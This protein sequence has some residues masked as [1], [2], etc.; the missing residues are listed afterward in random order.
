[1]TA[2]RRA[3]LAALRV[4]QTLSTF[5][6]GA[7]VLGQIARRS[8]E[9]TYRLDDLSITIPNVGGARVPLYEVY[10]EDQY[11]LD[12]FAQDLG[13]APHL[14]DV[15]AHVGTFA[16]DFARRFPNATAQLF[17]PTPSTGEYLARNVA[18]NGLAD[19]FTVNHAALA[20]VAGTFLMVDN[21]LASGHNG[22]LRLGTG[23]GREIEVP[24]QGANDVL[25]AVPQ[26][27]LV[28]MDVEGAEYD[29]VL[30]TPTETWSRVRR[31]VMEYH[32]LE[33]HR[34]EQIVDHLGAAGLAEVRRVPYNDEGLGMAWFARDLDP[35]T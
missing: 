31:V 35:R 3:R 30:A 10:A 15:G 8:D 14:V 2:A 19:R 5:S 33:G 16:V 22:I 7:S 9:L 21:G 34:L 17:E 11:A 32:P 12:W 27:D 26:V 6:N 20:S 18:D 28:K 23:L 4:R 25:L 13:P 29:I 24:G 1:M